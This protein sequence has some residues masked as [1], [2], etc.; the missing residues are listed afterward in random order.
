MTKPTQEL[1]KNMTTRALYIDGNWISGYGKEFS[2]HDPWSGEVLWKAPAASPTDVN[3]AVLAAHAAKKE[4]STKSLEAR[5]NFLNRFKQ[6]LETKAVEFAVQISKETGKPLWESR[7]EVAAMVAKVAISIAAYGDRC[8]TVENPSFATH[9]KPHGVVAVLGPFN[10]PGHLPNGHIIPALLAGNT[11]VYK[12]SEHT[13]ATAEL[14]M[15]LFQ[16]AELPKGVLNLVQGGATVG[17]ALAKHPDINGLFMTGS[18][19][20]GKS[21]LHYFAGH[22]DKIVALE[23]GGNN[24]LIVSSVKDLKAAALMTIQSAYLTAGQRCTCARRLIVVNNAPFLETLKEMVPKIVIGHYK[25]EKEPFM[26]PVI[27]QSAAVKGLLFQAS[28]QGHGAEIVIP[29]THEKEGT[30]RVKPGILDVTLCGKRPDEEIFAPLLQLIRV[31]TF[32]QAIEEANRTEYGLAAALFSESE[33]EYREFFQTIRAGIVNW[34]RPTTGASSEAP[35]GGIGKSGNHRPSAYYAADYCSY[36]VASSLSPEIA[37][38]P[39]LPPGLS[40]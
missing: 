12:P 15:R 32:K 7:G 30:G 9:H 10:F 26:G 37:I 34:N 38:P 6:I 14:Y 27:S 23:M 40:L 28:L 39:S 13:P 22:P 11:V 16:E 36:P 24:P 31:D 33:E 18:F 25:G 20:T 4:W 35:F 1:K 17:E 3:R 21:L 2:S 19:A 5:I 8:K 29:F